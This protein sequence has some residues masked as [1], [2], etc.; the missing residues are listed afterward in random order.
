MTSRPAS[1][2]SSRRRSGTSRTSRC[3]RCACCARSTWSRRRTRGGRACCCG[4]TASRRRVVSY[5]DAVERRRAPG[6]GRA[7]AGGRVGGAGERRRARRGSRTRA[8][9]WCAARSRQASRWCRC[10]VPSAVTALVSVAGLP[11]D[12]FAFEGFLPARAAARAARLRALAARDAGARV[13]RGGAPAGGLPRRRAGGA[14]RSRGGDR[15]R[16]DEGPRG[17]APRTAE[18]PAVGR[19]RRRPRRGHGARDR[20]RRTIASRSPAGAMDDAIRHALAAGRSVRELSEEVARSL[21]C[22]R[23]E[24]Y[25]RALELRGG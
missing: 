20:T 1:S 11:V 16:A 6:A 18:R 13:P 8:I 19:G 22:S 17:A 24:V 2:T 23:R 25:R 4:R 12:R 9:I 10:R 5:Y 21:G 14:G 3:G 15:P 7:D